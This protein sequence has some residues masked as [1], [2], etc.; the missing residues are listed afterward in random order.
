[1]SKTYNNMVQQADKGYYYESISEAQS[2]TE[3]C[4][5][6]LFCFVYLLCQISDRKH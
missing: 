6:R 3:I 2:R 4:F 1:M 5:Q